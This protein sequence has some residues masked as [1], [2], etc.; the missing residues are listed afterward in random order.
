MVAGSTIIFN[1]ATQAQANDFAGGTVVF[2]GSIKPVDIS[3]TD[4]PGTVLTNEAVTLTAGGHT[5][6]FGADELN[7]STLTFT[8]SDGHLYTG[9]AAVDTQ[10]LLSTADDQSV[11]Y[12]F[13]GDDAF[14]VDATNT[15]SWIVDGGA[16]NDT[17][18]FS[19]QTGHDTGHYLFGGAGDD[20]I[21]GSAGNDHIYGN[22][23]TSVAGDADGNDIITLGDGNNYVNGNAGDDTIHGGAGSNRIYGGAGND[24][25]DVTG[26][27][28][29]HVNGNKG[30]DHIDASAATGNN[31]LH[32]GA[33]NDVITSGTG[34]DTLSGDLGD[35]HL[36]VSGTAADHHLT[37][38]T[39]GD[40][41]DTFDFSAAGS[42][43]SVD[44]NGTTV[45]AGTFGAH[46]F[47]QEVTDFT[48]GTDHLSIDPLVTVDATHDVDALATNFANVSD[49]HQAAVTALTGG[50]T[51]VAT[52]VG[53]DTYLFYSGGDEVIK[54]DHT[55]AS[56]IDYH[57]F[58]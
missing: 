23:L 36:I 37:V 27:G 42:A 1:T 57:S 29:N 48:V 25:V 20:T 19:A 53:A 18:D 44:I 43:A 28:S 24:I 50:D 51:V 10:T 9:T 54:L 46:T 2:D 40:G 49:A 52:Q 5:L 8:G 33:G 39:G 45:G 13:A 4:V 41:A 17:I 21:T 7:A 14:T 15:G 3:A 38:L 22:A 32:G 35:D 30:D 26:A 56:S 31:D 11:A 6:T 12:G 34:H 16:G 47:Y 58:A 55:T